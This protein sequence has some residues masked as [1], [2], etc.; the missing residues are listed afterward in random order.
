MK[1]ARCGSISRLRNS[2][3]IEVEPV[4]IMLELEPLIND[5]VSPALAE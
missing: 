4:T 3:E 5:S 2:V 1:T